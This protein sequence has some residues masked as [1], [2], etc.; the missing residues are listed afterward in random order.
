M[1]EKKR[2]VSLPWGIIQGHV[3]NPEWH[4]QSPFHDTA[5]KRDQFVY[6]FE[7]GRKSNHPFQ[8]K[9]SIYL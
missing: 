4:C 1:K 2:L 7:L 8:E 3:A 6:T 5:F 9:L